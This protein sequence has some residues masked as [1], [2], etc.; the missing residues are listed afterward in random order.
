MEVLLFVDNRKIMNQLTVGASGESG[1]K[2][3]KCNGDQVALS[4]Y[5]SSVSGSE[6][7]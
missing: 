1:S 5:C 3:G 4:V 2:I 7:E 6:E